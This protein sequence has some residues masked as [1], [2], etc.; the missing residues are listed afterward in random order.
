MTFFR[1][2]EGRIH[3]GRIGALICVF[4]LLLGFQDMLHLDPLWLCRLI[5]LAGWR[6]SFGAKEPPRTRPEFAHSPK[7]IVGVVMVWLGAIGQ[8][9]VIGQSIWTKHY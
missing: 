3:Y 2:S 7:I 9:Y 1:T 8:L 5:F 4:S 6:F